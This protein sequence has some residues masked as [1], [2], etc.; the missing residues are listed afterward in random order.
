MPNEMSNHEIIDVTQ[1]AV[2]NVADKVVG[3]I[4][5]TAESM[6]HGEVF[7][8]S[9]EFWVGFSFILVLLGLARPVGKIVYKMLRKRSADIAARIDETTQLK[10]DA[11]KL[12]AE[13]E[14]KYRHA[15][16]EAQEILARSE[17]EINLLKKE[18]LTQ[19]E[20]EMSS[21][22]REALE[23]INATQDK[24]VQEV[25]YLAVSKAINNVKSVLSK[26]LTDK[27]KDRMIDESIELVKTIAK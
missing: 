18:K 2:L 13:Y 7:Y 19:L 1:S 3:A 14:N 10:E 23:R 8:L 22:E 12:L 4:E 25:L 16:Q 15:E 9:P 27:D 24:A 6:G 26:K 11:Q 17:R 5:N 21:K 20:Q